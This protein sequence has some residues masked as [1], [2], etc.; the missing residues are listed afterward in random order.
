MI[1]EEERN[2]RKKRSTQDVFGKT[3]NLVERNLERKSISKRL[4]F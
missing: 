1:A 4:K 3:I 2:A